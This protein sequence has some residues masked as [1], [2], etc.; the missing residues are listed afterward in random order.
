MNNGYERCEVRED[1]QCFGTATAT[2]REPYTSRGFKV[3]CC[4]PHAVDLERYGYI[5]ETADES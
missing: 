5:R 1:S 2:M 3:R 4:E